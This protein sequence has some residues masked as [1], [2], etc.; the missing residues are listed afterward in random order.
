MIMEHRLVVCPASTSALE[1]LEEA[2]MIPEHC[3]VARH[4]R[5][6]V[7]YAVKKAIVS[8]CGQMR[9]VNV[10]VGAG[11]ASQRCGCQQR[12]VVAESG[13]MEGMRHFQGYCLRFLPELEWRVGE[14]VEVE[15]ADVQLAVWLMME[16]KFL[17]Q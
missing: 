16:S 4:R 7:L 11:A 12:C 17:C 3:E 6:P 13:C 14:A 2:G 8:S 15:V 10:L 1:A 5:Q 9:R